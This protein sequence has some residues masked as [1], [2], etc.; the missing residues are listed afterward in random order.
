MCFI[1]TVFPCIFL[2]FTIIWML[3]RTAAWFT[4]MI[5]TAQD[6]YTI[7][8]RLFN[9]LTLEE[10]FIEVLRELDTNIISYLLKLI[11][12]YD[13][14][15]TTLFIEDLT[16]IFWVTCCNKHDLDIFS[17]FFSWKKLFNSWFCEFILDT[18]FAFLLIFNL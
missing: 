18:N 11:Y 12:C 4:I 16:N 2:P 5:R 6:L 15:Y 17:S 14:R 1:I 8:E 10:I 7:I 13:Y 9:C 3:M